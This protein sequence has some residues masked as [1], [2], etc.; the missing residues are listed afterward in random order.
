MLFPGPF[1]DTLTDDFVILALKEA[2]KTAIPEIANSDQGSQFTGNAYLSMLLENNVKI[3]MDGRRRALDNIFTERLWRTVKYEDIYL[4]EYCSPRELRA[5][6]SA[7]FDWYNNERAH[8]SLN[9]RTPAQ[10]YFSE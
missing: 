9:Y 5:G 2:L 10:V 7:Y 1:Q 8:Q 4:K 6:L 3:S